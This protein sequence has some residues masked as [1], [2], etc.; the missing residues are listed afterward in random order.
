MELDHAENGKICVE[1]FEQSETGWYDVILMD[2]RM[3]VM[4][5]Y[6]AAAAIR[7]LARDDAGKIPIIA[8]SADAFAD[9]VKKCFACGMNAHTAKPYDLGE[10]IRLMSEN[11]RT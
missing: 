2:L 4:T 11:L 8:V 9:D 6:E 3:P 10:L 5:G 7:G 1:K